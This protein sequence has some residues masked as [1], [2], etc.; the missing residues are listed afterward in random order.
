MYDPV[1]E[2]W[3]FTGSLARAHAGHFAFALPSGAVLVLG[4]DQAE[5]YDP[6]TGTWSP[7]GNSC[8]MDSISVA[9][10]LQTGKVLVID[11]T[12]YR[13]DA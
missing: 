1:T 7:A 11:G 9:T 5:L 2:T 13:A 4:G 3:S 12:P 8:P 10:M 6:A